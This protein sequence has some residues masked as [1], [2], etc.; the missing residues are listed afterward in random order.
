ML[1]CLKVMAL[2]NLVKGLALKLS[3]DAKIL[4][5]SDSQQFQ[6]RLERWSDLDL[7][8]PSAIVVPATEQDVAIV[9]GSIP[10]K[11]PSG[12]LMREYRSNTQ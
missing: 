11:F 1:Y 7:K 9:V 12:C 6:R 4:T 5:A 3:P 8:I 10:R 2:N